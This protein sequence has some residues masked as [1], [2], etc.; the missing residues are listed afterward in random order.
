MG[1]TGDGTF[2][3]DIDGGGFTIFA[4]LQQTT[5]GP[6]PDGLHTFTVRENGD[7][8]DT[9]VNFTVDTIKPTLTS[10]LAPAP[11]LAGW[12]TGSVVV[13][14]NCTDAGSG[15]ASFSSPATLAA[16]GT[17]NGTCTD[18]AGNVQTSSTAVKIDGVAPVYTLA[19]APPAPGGKDI[20]GN[21]TGWYVSG[22]PTANYTCTDAG[23]GLAPSACP[24]DFQLAAD[25]IHTETPPG[26][27]ADIAG[28]TT[29]A[30]PAVTIKRDATAPS[31]PGLSTIGPVTNQLR[32]PF[33][34]TNSTDA[35]SGV[36]GYELVVKSGGS[37]K[38][39]SA[40]DPAFAG[41]GK[42]IPVS[43]G[44][45]VSAQLPADL[46]D[47]GSYTWTVKAFDAA[48]NSN[49]SSQG[50]FSIDTSTPNAPSITAGP[51]DGGATNSTKP[52]WTFAG[53]PGAQF[54]WQ[55]KTQ[56]GVVI[57]PFAAYSATT[58]FTPAAALVDG[59]YLFEVQQQAP[60]GKE[61]A[62]T[63]AIF[64][65][66]TV[67]PGQP[68]ITSS[69]G[70]NAT[71]QPTFSW[72]AAE[73]GGSF[74]WQ[75]TGIGGARVQGP[76]DTTSTTLQVP[77]ALANGS[78]VFQVRQRDHAGNLSEWSFPE[79][80]T[81]TGGSS[82]GGNNGGDGGGTVTKYRPGTRNASLMYPKVGAVLNPT[83][84]L[85][86]WKRTPGA[87]LYNVQVFILS[88]TGGTTVKKVHYAFPHGLSYRVPKRI[89]KPGQR[90]VWRVWPYL[91]R[92]KRYTKNPFGISWFDTKT[93]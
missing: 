87:T 51:V 39:D 55:L 28:N 80:F 44:S 60:N 48:G 90:Y 74:N 20:A 89:L 52:A 50:A 40:T 31:K 10:T 46:N 92:V 62:L 43:G 88:S 83:K 13:T 72:R 16:T 42:L 21:A 9:A 7:S 61:S 17:A 54:K 15:V 33:Q 82:G 27:V 53:L 41:S 68:V 75:I 35:T 76:L 5:L 30:P 12:N 78:Y 36:A 57:T 3:W 8:G 65:V 70:A 56:A 14:W 49:T 86:R 38:Y 47:G 58:S 4:P 22:T 23:S 37:T 1:S 32:P 11:N 2:A 6:L 45:Q 73:P 34:W 29:A 69:P 66:D 71:S 25:G 64:A 67:A 19:V 59:T 63:S 93:G 77:A 91:G 18:K 85:L 24:A 84:V 26:P 79:P 81:V